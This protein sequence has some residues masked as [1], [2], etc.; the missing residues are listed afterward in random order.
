[1]PTA[2]DTAS[3]RPTHPA[4]LSTRSAVSMNPLPVELVQTIHAAL[5]GTRGAAVAVASVEP[6][7]GHV[8]FSGV[9]NIAGVVLGS[10]K[11]YAMVSHNGTAGHEARNIKEFVYPWDSDAVIVVHSD[12]LSSN[13]DPAAFPG[14]LRRH[15]SII[16][17]VLYREAARDRD[18]AC[19]IVGKSR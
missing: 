8:R 5:R 10:A 12:G 9:G 18:D 4:R 3:P 11:A 6:G 14:L 1:M 15:P 7:Q 2:L 19:V 16:A 13:W 17:A